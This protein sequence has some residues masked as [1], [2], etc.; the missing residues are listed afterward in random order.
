MGKGGDARA[1]AFMEISQDAV[2]HDYYGVGIDANIITYVS[3]R[4][5]ISG[6]NRLEALGVLVRAPRSPTHEQRKASTSPHGLGPS[7][8]LPGG[9]HHHR[10]RQDR[11]AAEARSGK[12][13][14]FGSRQDAG[15]SLQTRLA[16]NR[17]LS[18]PQP[19]PLH[20][21]SEFYHT[22]QASDE[23]CGLH[24]R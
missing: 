23:Q 1:C 18:P 5:L 14:R 24:Y 15:G 2:D 7:P 10:P 11:T 12:P 17:H 3:I 9:R 6:V 13:I 4:A 16:A 20:I 21:P 19:Y 22:I 8:A